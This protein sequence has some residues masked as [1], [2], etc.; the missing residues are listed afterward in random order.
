MYVFDYSSSSYVVYN[1]VR[2]TRY[3][4][5]NLLVNLYHQVMSGDLIII[6]VFPIN[7]I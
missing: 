2:P 5:R 6:I 7:I 3:E 1:A 4:T